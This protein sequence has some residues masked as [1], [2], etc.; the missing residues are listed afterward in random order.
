MYFSPVV[1]LKKEGDKKAT[2]GRVVIKSIYLIDE[3]PEK[4]NGN[5]GLVP[6]YSISD[7]MILVKGYCDISTTY[8]EAENEK[9]LLKHFNK[10]FH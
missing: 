2:P 1:V 5:D 10:N 4:G 9:K 7:H 8:T 6:N 3:P